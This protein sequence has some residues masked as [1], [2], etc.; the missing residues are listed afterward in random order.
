MDILN[1]GVHGVWAIAPNGDAVYVMSSYALFLRNSL[2]AGIGVALF[3]CL[4]FL[5]YDLRER[6]YVR[7]VGGIRFV[8]CGRVF[9]SFGLAKGVR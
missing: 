4:V 3:M 6:S 7:K 9:G 2:L 1:M 5:A 8:R